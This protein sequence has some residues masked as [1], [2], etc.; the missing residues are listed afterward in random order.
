MCHIVSIIST[1]MIYPLGHSLSP[2]HFVFW[3]RD[4][5]CFTYDI[6]NTLLE[7]RFIIPLPSKAILSYL[8]KRK[9]N[10]RR[11]L[12]SCDKKKIVSGI[13]PNSINYFLQTNTLFSPPPIFGEFSIT[14]P[15]PV[16]PIQVYS[17][18]A[19]IH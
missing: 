17:H 10:Y 2:F 4:K 6:K 7:N 1:E 14:G 5:L 18:I 13:T 11:S 15:V 8:S 19:F 9:T 16:F 12:W 3:F